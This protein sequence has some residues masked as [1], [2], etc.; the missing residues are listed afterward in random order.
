MAR[1]PLDA[2]HRGEIVT[3]AYEAPHFAAAALSPAEVNW[4]GRGTCQTAK[5]C[6]FAIR[7]RAGAPRLQTSLSGGD[8]VRGVD[9]DL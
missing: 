9:L 5:R 3:V 1:Y 4:P 8:A 7:H 6:R 2:L